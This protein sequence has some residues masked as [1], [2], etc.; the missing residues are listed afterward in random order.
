MIRGLIGKLLTFFV[1]GAVFVAVW[2]ANNGDL[3]SVADWVWSVLNL[4]ADFVT[5]LWNG[6]TNVTSTPAPPS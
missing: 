3:T 6:F 1:L 5:T 4:G 2:R